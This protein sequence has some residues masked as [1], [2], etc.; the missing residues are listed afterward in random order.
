MFCLQKTYDLLT[1]CYEELQYHFDTN[2]AQ[3]EFI[4]ENTSRIRAAKYPKLALRQKQELVA[5][6]KGTPQ[7]RRKQ[8]RRSKRRKR[9]PR[10]RSEASCISFR[11]KQRR[12]QSCLPLRKIAA[13]CRRPKPQLFCNQISG[14]VHFDPIHYLIARHRNDGNPLERKSVS[15]R[16]ITRDTLCTGVKHVAVILDAKP[17]LRPIQVTDEARSAHRATPIVRHRDSIVNLRSRQTV[18]TVC[19]RKTEQQEQNRLHGRGTSFGQ[20]AQRNTSA[21]YSVLTRRP[22]HVGAQT[23]QRRHE[24]PFPEAENISA[25][26]FFWRTQQRSIRSRQLRTYS[27]QINERCIAGILNECQFGRNDIYVSYAKKG[28]RSV[29]ALMNMKSKILTFSAVSSRRDQH[30]Q[31]MPKSPCKAVNITADFLGGNRHPQRGRPSKAR[32]IR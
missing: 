27:K 11:K 28:P 9:R 6:N 23:S 30:M 2:R 17:R 22:L 15:P 29:I 14:P 13:V 16:R 3:T 8:H 7:Q 26:R 24:L 19:T 12:S 18:A 1:W 32:R 20:I 21:L 31:R 5:T 10:L 4:I 25:C